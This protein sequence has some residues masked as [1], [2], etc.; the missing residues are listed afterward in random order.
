MFIIIIENLNAFKGKK[1]K[2]RKNFKMPFR[3]LK[4]DACCKFT[5]HPFEALVNRSIQTSDMIN[6]SSKRLPLNS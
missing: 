5:S 3:V 1:N 2:D 6:S 4:K